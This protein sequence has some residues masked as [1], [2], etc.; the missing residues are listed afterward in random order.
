MSFRRIW[1]IGCGN[2]ASAMLRRWLDCGLDPA[3]VTVVRPSGAPVAPGVRVVRDVP[4]EP[5][6][7]LLLIGVKP[8]MLGD[9]APGLQAA[10]TGIVLSILAGTKLTSL[11]AHF[12]EAGSI[13]RAMP[14]LPVA[15][16]KGV[17]ATVSDAPIAP[18]LARLLDQLGLVE[19]VPDETL[20]DAVTALA[21]SGPAFAYRFVD[22]LAKGGAALGL[23]PAQ[24]SR[25]AL[26]T[27]GGALALARG[28]G[29]PP[30]ELAE[31]VASK[32]GST[33]EG[34]NVLDTG[35][36]DLVAECLAAAT[37]R[38]AELGG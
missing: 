3:H 5:A 6:P 34:L 12:P 13:V 10:S 27:V 11:R 37:R 7:E 29:T 20:F 15:L 8:Q 26:A 31:R 17:V 30:G 22:A 28:D 25:L 35:L 18:D 14:N 2:M 1:L 24:A 4:D 38:N 23:D 16:G 9:V 36:D 19:H 21:G 32:G 33:R